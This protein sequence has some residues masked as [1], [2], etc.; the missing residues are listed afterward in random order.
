MVAIA[1]I[2]QFETGIASVLQALD[3][4]VEARALA[5]DLPIVGDAL[6][7]QN[8]AATEALALARDALLAGLQTLQDATGHSI[9]E[10]EDA[11][12]AALDE[13][14]LGDLLQVNETGT[15]F[16]VSLTLSEGASTNVALAGDLGMPG[17]GLSVSGSAD[18]S[19]TA[20]LSL[21]VG[22]DGAGFYLDTT[23]DDLELQ[24]GVTNV[25]FDAGATLGPLTFSATDAGTALAGT[26]ALD[27]TDADGKL[28][29][30]EAV[31]LAASLNAG[32]EMAMDLGADFGTAALPSVSA[33]LNVDWNF[34]D[35]TVTPYDQNLTFGALPEIE[36]RDV[37]LDLGTFL[38]NVVL[39]IV[40]TVGPLIE[41]IRIALDIL[42][43]DIEMLKLL[44]ALG[45]PAGQ[46]RRRQGQHA[47]PAEAGGSD[48][49]P[50]TARSLHRGRADD[51]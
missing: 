20:D 17:L 41:P 14:G 35:A 19:A 7:G 43:T 44:P 12:N 10:I 50:R 24:V 37:T 48:P 6:S 15:G 28:R 11:L 4:A 21:T 32:A 18:L 9:T 8:S 27:L 1:D 29:V 33:T 49:R 13:A 3:Q 40:D 16:E 31:N 47:R 2:R 22:M 5:E 36:L 38:E 39:P 42:T 51:P 34:V 30:G 26:F 45:D 25:T 23:S 46:E